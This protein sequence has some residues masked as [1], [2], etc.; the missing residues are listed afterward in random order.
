MS[1]AYVIVDVF[2]E[3]NLSETVLLLRAEDG[4]DARMRIFT[5]RR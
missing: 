4:G 2:T 5:P 1:L 3:M